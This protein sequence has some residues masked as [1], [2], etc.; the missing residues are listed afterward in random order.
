[1]Q[2]L[3]RLYSLHVTWHSLN[4]RLRLCLTRLRFSSYLKQF[5]W[6]SLRVFVVVSSLVFFLLCVQST[7]T[8]DLFEFRLLTKLEYIEMCQTRQNRRLTFS[9]VHLMSRGALNNA[10]RFTDECNHLINKYMEMLKY[11]NRSHVCY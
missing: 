4:F 2:N 8:F 1:M 5:L 10:K 9:I 3:N 11:N 7:T 6:F